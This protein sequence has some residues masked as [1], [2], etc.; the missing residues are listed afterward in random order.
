MR[1]IYILLGLLICLNGFATAPT[2]PAKNFSVNSREGSFLNI[3]WQAGNGTR[4]VII[5]RAGAP[6]QSRPENGKDYAENTK[7]GDGQQLLPG[8]YVIYDNAFTSFFVTGLAPGTTYFFAIFEYNG[9]GV[10]TEYL[11]DPYLA[12]S[13]S[14]VS[15]PTAQT[16][17]LSF[18]NITT[19]SV[20][21]DW[22]AGDG[23]RRLVLVRKDSPVNADPVDLINY[24]GNSSF[25]AGA[26]VGTGNY[27]V[28]TNTGTGTTITNLVD[29]KSVV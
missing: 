29:R 1:H 12:A 16:H 18:S 5:A 23:F 10:N 15:A 21:A 3:G 27:S 13:A 6:V 17:D 19:S 20:K 14:T 11:L 28:Y 25:M 9:T 8:E 7:F 2:N 4:R 24:S 26:Q 22:L